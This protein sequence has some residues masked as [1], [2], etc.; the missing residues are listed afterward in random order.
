M[1]GKVAVVD[2]LWATVGSANLDP[3]SLSLSLEANV[4]IRDAEFAAT[5]QRHL[6]HLMEHDC[7]R[8]S[9]A[10]LPRLTMWRNLIVSL[11]Y[12]ISRGF[13][14]WLR[15]PYSGSRVRSFVGGQRVD[16]WTGFDASASSD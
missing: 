3:L 14:R 5:L 7:E 4:M 1:H 15:L 13:P 2:G 16:T 6:Q 11:A 8:L 12:H 10:V 9:P